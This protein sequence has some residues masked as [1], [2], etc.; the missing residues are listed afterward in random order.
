[1]LDCQ[2]QQY[3]GPKTHPQAYTGGHSVVLED[4][5][6][7]GGQL[8]EVGIHHEGRQILRVGL[9]PR[10]CQVQTVEL[11]QNHLHFPQREKYLNSNK[12]EDYWYK[13]EYCLELAATTT[14]FLSLVFSVH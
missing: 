2:P 1:M 3:V 9:L 14:I 5:A 10:Q 8:L 12:Q 11:G 13:G 7:Q 4:R 6:G